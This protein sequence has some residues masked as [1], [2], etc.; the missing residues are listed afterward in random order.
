MNVLKISP[1]KQVSPGLHPSIIRTE[2]IKEDLGFLHK[3][4]A[5]T[6]LQLC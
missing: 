5:G 6:R 1:L 2:R 3:A 4:Q